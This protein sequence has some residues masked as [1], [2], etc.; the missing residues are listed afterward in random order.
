[1]SVY[2]E[3]CCLHIEISLF[4]YLDVGL[5]GATIDFSYAVK[6]FR[7]LGSTNCYLEVFR[8]NILAYPVINC[9]ILDAI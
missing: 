4:W 1:M 8:I 3:F 9:T 6:I 7:Y 5:T 2:N